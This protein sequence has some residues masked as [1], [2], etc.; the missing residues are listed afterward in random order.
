MARRRV[1]GARRMARR[2][3]LA[4]VRQIPAPSCG[5]STPCRSEGRCSCLPEDLGPVL[6]DAAAVLIDYSQGGIYPSPRYQDQLAVAARGA[7]ALWIADETV[8]G[9]GRQGRWM[10]FQR[11]TERPDIV[12]LGKGL[13]GGMAPAAA[14][15]L[16]T[17]V[18]DLMR[19]QRWQSYSTFRGHPISVA[20]VSA[21]VRGIDREGLVQRVD[22]LDAK[23]RATFSKLASDHPAVERF[24]GLGLHWTVELHGLDWRSWHADTDET[25]LADEVVGTA[26]GA[27]ALLAT[28]A[29]ATSIFFA[30]PLIASDA[31]IDA[32][33]QALDLGLSMADKRMA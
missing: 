5:V 3:R 15:V 29:E 2:P 26:L 19:D 4:E 27:G 20:A 7:G 12:T 25:T 32:A 33:L 6:G 11:G 17:R 21:T 14:L 22:S 13:A 18:T 9:L 28:S 16:S 1:V 8:T 24:D 23:M 10:T 31:E 30:P